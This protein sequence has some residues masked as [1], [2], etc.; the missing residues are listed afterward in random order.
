[1][2]HRYFKIICLS[3][4]IL[5][6]L[7]L[8]PLSLSAAEITHSISTGSPTGVYYAAGTAVAKLFNRNGRSMAAPC[9]KSLGRV[10]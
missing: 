1:M 2:P 4:I 9:D 10:H 8:L 7:V 5:Q 6:A 3:L